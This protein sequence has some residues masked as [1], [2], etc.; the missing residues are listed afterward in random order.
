MFNFKIIVLI[1]GN[2]TNLQCLIDNY[3]NIPSKNIKIVSVISNKKNAYGLIR[4]SNSN[5]PTYY[6]P[7]LKKTKN[8]SRIEY[9]A[10]LSNLINTIDYDL[11]VCAG[12]MHI[13]SSEFLNKHQKIINLHPALPNTFPGKNGIIDTFQAYKNSKVKKAGC[14]VHWVIPEIDAGK[15]IYKIEIDL[16]NEIDLTE[17][18]L[19]EKIQKIEK[20]CLLKAI[21][22]LI[23]NNDL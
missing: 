16:T 1:S 5:I 7:F 12:W 18:K 23:E 13:L 15:V 6:C 17:E 21:D 11:I 9:D 4:A 2:G 14:M 19:K 20:D 22:I 8:E 10:K 3:H